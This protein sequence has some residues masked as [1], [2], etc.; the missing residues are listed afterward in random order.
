M[1]ALIA[2]HWPGRWG[3]IINLGA[4][5]ANVLGQA[6]ISAYDAAK[7]AVVLAVAILS[8]GRGQERIT[9][10]VVQSL[11]IERRN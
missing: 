9:V 11:S 7:A 5:G 6:K 4:G 3:R 10:N 2:V 8:P 1:S